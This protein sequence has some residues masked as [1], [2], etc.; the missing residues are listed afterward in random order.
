MIYS[1]DIERRVLSGILQHQ[2]DWGEIANLINSDDFYSK[3]TKVH[4]TL[5][6]MLKSALDN[7]EEI[8]ETIL[9]QRIN[10]LGVSFPDS[11]DVTEY[12]NNLAFKKITKEVFESSIRELKKYSVRRLL[13]E[14]GLE[15]Q[16]KV[17]G[18][19]PQK[20]YGAILDEIDNIYN[21]AISNFEF[22]EDNVVN[23]AEIA[24]EIV[25]DRGENPPEEVGFLGP[26]KTIN[27]IYGSLLRP[28]NIAVVCAR[29]KAGKSLTMLDY[30]LKVSYKYHVPILH[31]D[32][33]EMSEEELIFRMVAANS[34]VPMYLLESGKW[35][36]HGYGEWTAKEVVDRVRSVWKKLDGLEILYK[37]VAGMTS[38]EMVAAMKRIYYSKVGRGNEMIFSFDYLK[39]D[40]SNLGKG[41][42][43]AWVGKMLHNFKQT[44]SRELKFDGKPVVSMFTAVQANRTGIANSRNG[45]TDDESIVSLSDNITQFCSH[46]FILRKKTIEELTDEGPDFGTHKLIPTVARHLGEDPFGHLNPVELLDGSKADNFINLK[47]ENFNVEDCGDLRDIVNKQ[48]GLDINAD[49]DTED[50]LPDEF[51]EA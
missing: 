6:K 50:D 26:H 46:L 39:T 35:R 18:V 45:I 29:S 2:K 20:S 23:L 4:V 22:G 30:L 16:N 38:E 37:N 21:E 43:W 41:S 36:T 34:G 44:I 14:K 8:D 7:A 19:D 49:N 31:F 5:F 27:K 10:Q 3:D 11:I 42:E 1:L 12:I 15:I 24:E 13:F 33:G 17:K 28:G 25:E 32:N 9:I 51:Y 48:K 47:I 40:F